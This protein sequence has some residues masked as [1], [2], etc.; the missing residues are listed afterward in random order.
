MLYTK[1]EIMSEIA[2]EKNDHNRVC[3][4]KFAFML[5]NRIRRYLQKPERIL[6]EYIKS[7]DTVFDLGCGPGFFSVD[8][9]KMVGPTGT[10]VAVDLQ[11]EM[12]KHLKRKAKKHKIQ[13]RIICHKCGS[14]DI[15][16]DTQAD[17]ILAFYM[18]HEVPDT[19]YCLMQLKKMLKPA[20]RILVVEPKMHVSEALFRSMI[21]QAEEVGLKALDYPRRKGGRSVVLGIRNS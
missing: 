4:H 11:E 5:D 1:G 13:D 21:M 20:G 10:V 15:G 12:F 16:L 18:I 17:F 2:L 9:A 3:P 8:M 19:R 6:R 14:R 7:G